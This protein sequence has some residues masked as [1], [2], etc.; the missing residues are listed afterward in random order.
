MSTQPTDEELRAGVKAIEACRF[1]KTSDEKMAAEVHRAMQSA[2]TP[3]PCA[4]DDVE[5]VARALWEHEFRGEGK[6][7]VNVENPEDWY[8]Q[9]RA[10]IAALGTTPSIV[11]QEKLDG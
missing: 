5:R 3:P 11:G 2:R 6:W 4:G 9:A 10:A 8:S 1:H 7:P